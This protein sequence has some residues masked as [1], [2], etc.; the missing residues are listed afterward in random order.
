MSKTIETTSRQSLFLAEIKAGNNTA[1]LL[2]A[3]FAISNSAALQM[4]K[5]LEGGGLIV[6]DGYAE[7]SGQ[8]GGG[9]AAKRFKVKR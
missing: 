9:A 8:N 2:S 3:K 6:Q 1:P 5:R 7:R 4:L